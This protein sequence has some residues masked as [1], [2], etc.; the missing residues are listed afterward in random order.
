MSDFDIL[1]HDIPCYICFAHIRADSAFYSPGA[2]VGWR[3][4]TSLVCRRAGAVV[5]TVLLPAVT[6]AAAA[7]KP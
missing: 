3:E 2:F 4:H 1:C 7:R 5:G 6:V